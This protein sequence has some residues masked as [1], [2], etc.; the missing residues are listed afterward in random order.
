M[1]DKNGD[2]HSNDEEK[3][4]G[5][6][7]AESDVAAL[8]RSQPVGLASG[9]PGERRVVAAVVGPQRDEGDAGPAE[10]PVVPDGAAADASLRHEVALEVRLEQGHRGIAVGVEVEATAALFDGRQGW[11]TC[12]S[13]EVCEGVRSAEVHHLKASGAIGISGQS[14]GASDRVKGILV[15][16]VPVLNG[17]GSWGGKTPAVAVEIG[18][19]V[20]ATGTPSSLSTGKCLPVY[21]SAP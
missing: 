12:L 19:V 20:L 18:L 5:Q 11:S 17:G 1:R 3:Q 9:E 10:Q 8:G 14:P 7:A 21:K 2:E 15:L 6:A 16:L 4:E 13:P